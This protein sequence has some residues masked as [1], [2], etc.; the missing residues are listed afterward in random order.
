VGKR[1]RRR[2]MAQRALSAIDALAAETLFA[3]SGY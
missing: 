1:E 3:P 2:A